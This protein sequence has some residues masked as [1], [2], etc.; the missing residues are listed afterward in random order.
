MVPGAMFLLP[1]FCVSLLADPFLLPPRSQFFGNGIIVEMESS[2]LVFAVNPLFGGHRA[3]ETKLKEKGPIKRFMWAG[4]VLLENQ[5]SVPGRGVITRINATAGSLFKRGIITN[6]QLGAELIRRNAI[7]DVSPTLTF[8]QDGRHLHPRLDGI[9]A[10]PK[11]EFGNYAQWI[12]AVLES[13]VTEGIL[14][15]RDEQLETTGIADVVRKEE[16]RA[17]HLQVLRAFLEALPILADPQVTPGLTLQ[18]REVLTRSALPAA[19]LAFFQ[20]ESRL[21]PEELR[22]LTDNWVELQTYSL[23]AVERAWETLLIIPFPKAN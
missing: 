13:A 3:L 15:R 18:A 6:A 2:E 11:H 22:V 21:T 14:R 4:E 17:D 9:K 23:A 8:G 10:D 19:L 20:G 12:Y 16:V 7:W 1:L 5:S